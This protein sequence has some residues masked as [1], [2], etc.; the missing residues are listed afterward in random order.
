MILGDPAVDPHLPDHIALSA[1][2][3]LL[4]LGLVQGALVLRRRT[5]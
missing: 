4:I 3:A 1:G 5:A 2:L